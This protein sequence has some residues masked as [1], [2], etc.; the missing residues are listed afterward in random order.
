MRHQDPAFT[1]IELL[2]VIAII[3]VLIAMLFPALTSVQER[4]DKTKCLNNVHQIAVGGQNMFGE[5][6]DKMPNRSAWDAFGEAAEQ[7]MPYVKNVVDVFI[8]PANPGT[9]SLSGG[10]GPKCLMPTSGKYTCYELNGFLCSLGSPR[11]QS[12][13]TDFSLAAYGYDYPYDPADGKARA[14]STGVNAGYLDGH[15]AFLLDAN[16]GL[17]TTNLF[18]LRG[19]QVQ[20]VGG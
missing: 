2:V 16:M 3:A 11:S 18:Y 12:L 4:A 5:S 17:G 7:L 1:L 14:H 13:I 19:H 10:R 15:A 8:C 20:G 6:G 9:K